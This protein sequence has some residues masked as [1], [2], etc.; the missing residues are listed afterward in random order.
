MLMG[1]LH[2]SG[3]AEKRVVANGGCIKNEANKKRSGGDQKTARSATPK[4]QQQAHRARSK[5]YLK[6]TAYLE[7]RWLLLSSSSW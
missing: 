3:R 2:T 6:C 1:I 5:G 4:Q 7:T